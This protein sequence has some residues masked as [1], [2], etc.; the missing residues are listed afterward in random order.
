MRK[1]LYWLGDEDGATRLPAVEVTSY[2]V[3]LKDDEDF[4]RRSG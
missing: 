3:E 1:R 4:I 2:N